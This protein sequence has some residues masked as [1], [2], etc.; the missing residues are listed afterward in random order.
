MIK[1]FRRLRLKLLG[2]NKF[3][4]YLSYAI[5]EIILV[6]VG[7]LIALALNN[8]NQDRKERLLEVELLKE[9]HQDLSTSLLDLESGLEAILE[10]QERTKDL[11]D[12][13]MDG[14]PEE[15]IS[16]KDFLSIG[17]DD[18]FFPRTS[19]FA[20]LQ[21]AGFQV[22]TNDTLRQ[23]IVDHYELVNTRIV[24]LGRDHRKVSFRSVSEPYQ[25]QY[26]QLSDSTSFRV[27]SD[28]QDSTRM[29]LHKVVNYEALLKDE[30]F[31]MQLQFI[32]NSRGHKI[33]NYHWAIDSTKGLMN[34]IEEEIERLEN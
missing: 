33:R 19:G 13:I 29:F 7:I 25:N 10:Y 22:L 26:L 12:A 16:T 32:I 15:L 1:F 5:G 17:A 20:A 31:K 24:A 18:Q 21:S 9:I 30:Q 28:G 8:W 4:Q 27:H 6:V 23:D 34:A 14:Q 3:A 11:R 2:E